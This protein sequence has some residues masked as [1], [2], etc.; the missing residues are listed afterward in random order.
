MQSLAVMANRKNKIAEQGV[1]F[2]IK[3]PYNEVDKK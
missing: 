1:V 2:V 3:T